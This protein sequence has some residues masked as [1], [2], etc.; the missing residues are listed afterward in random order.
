MSIPMLQ[1]TMDL[2][3]YGWPIQ[4]WGYLVNEAPE[5]GH[6]LSANMLTLWKD[7]VGVFISF[8]L[9][10]AYPPPYHQK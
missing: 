5:D 9:K 4:K 3:T 6:K 7:Q 1:K 2:I 8:S 10:V